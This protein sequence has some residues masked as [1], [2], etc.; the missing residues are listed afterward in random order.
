M[1]LAVEYLV[2]AEASCQTG[3]EISALQWI[4]V[5]RIPRKVCTGWRNAVAALII[6]LVSR[7]GL[8]RPTVKE[9]SEEQLRIGVVPEELLATADR[10]LAPGILNRILSV[11][12]SNDLHYGGTVALNGS[13]NAA[14]SL[15][16]FIR[17]GPDMEAALGAWMF[18]SSS[19]ASFRLPPC[20]DSAEPRKLKDSDSLARH[21]QLQPVFYG[22]GRH[23]HAPKLRV[24]PIQVVA[25]ISQ[26]LI[27]V[28]RR[29]TLEG[30]NGQQRDHQSRWHDV[31]RPLGLLEKELTEGGHRRSTRGRMLEMRRSTWSGPGLTISRL[32]GR[33]R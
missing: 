14:P 22:I 2:E 30:R 32:R 12:F 5:G 20:S 29:D 23:R 16:P 26:Q 21:L 8:R 13:A 4:E 15:S 31:R 19:E 27:H 24:R 11:G 28:R 33:H 10:E 1:G 6:N 25:D 17:R 7:C 18:R 9:P 3:F